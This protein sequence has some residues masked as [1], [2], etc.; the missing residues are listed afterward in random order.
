M[1]LLLVV[2]ESLAPM[3]VVMI[4]FHAAVLRRPPKNPVPV[5]AGTLAVI[6]GMWMI[7]AGMDMGMRH[8][9]ED[10]AAK[11]SAPSMGLWA[12]FFPFLIGYAT[13]MAEPSLI[14]VSEK[15]EQVT[16]GGL[17]SFMFKTVVSLGVGV[18]L[19]AGVHRILSG[20]DIWPYLVG[21]YLLVLILTKLAPREAVPIAYDSGEVTT[22]TVTI[23]VIFALGLGLAK[24]KPG[25]N[26]IENGFGLIAVAAIF[27]VLFVLLYATAARF[28]ARVKSGRR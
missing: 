7:L 15:A 11:L 25:A 23:P 16:A 20:A 17:K 5:F 22:S 3:A 27:P 9:G 2:I 12:L 10:M 18:G 24:A 13:T 21:G 14:A 1:D 26:I 28:V 6:A 8:L 4:F 19:M